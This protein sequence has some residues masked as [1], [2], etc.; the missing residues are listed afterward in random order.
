MAGRVQYD[1]SGAHNVKVDYVGGGMA[2]VLGAR[3]AGVD[4]AHQITKIYGSANGTTA[5][6]VVAL[7]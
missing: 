3:L 1:I 4:H 2:V 6:G 7:Y 5:T